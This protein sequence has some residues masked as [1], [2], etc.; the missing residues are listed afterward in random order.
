MKKTKTLDRRRRQQRGTSLIE[1]M[2]A[3]AVL[4][5][6]LLGALQ[7]LLLASKQNADADK[8]TRASA[9]LTQTRS[10]LELYGWDRLNG[11]AGPAAECLDASGFTGLVD[12]LPTSGL[13]NTVSC[14]VDLDA[15][16]AS[17]P[18]ANRL[19]PGYRAE[20]SVTFRRLAVVFRDPVTPEDRAFRE[21]AVVIAWRNALGAFSNVTSL[22]GLY[23]PDPLT[24]N[25][26]N[27]EI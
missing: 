3:A 10:S 15:F 27:V 19:V 23:D 20:D 1:G 17:A 21:V 11:A 8:R 6:G 24:G 12:H 13:G 9:L 22:V 7:A 18:A 14:V 25:E 5:I 2:A 16:E 26:T 4:L